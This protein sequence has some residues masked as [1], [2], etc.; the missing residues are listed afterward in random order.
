MSVPAWIIELVTSS[1]TTR[2]AE[3]ITLPKPQSSRVRVTKCRAFLGALG[4]GASPSH[5]TTGAGVASTSD[6]AESIDAV[7]I[8]CPPKG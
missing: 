2:E 6:S 1:L 3:E 4:C 5:S 8:R 7:T